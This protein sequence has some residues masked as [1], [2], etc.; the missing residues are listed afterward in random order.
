MRSPRSNRVKDIA[1]WLADELSPATPTAS[2]EAAMLL[3]A[4]SSL[5]R[6][7]QIAKDHL[8]LTAAKIA[9]LS[10]WLM[11]RQRGEPI[12]YILGSKEFYGREFAVD[13]RVLIPRPETEQIVE[14]AKDYL[15]ERR[16]PT[17][18]VLDVGTG[19]GCIAITIA[20]ECLDSVVEAW[21]ISTDALDVARRNAKTLGAAVNFS[22]MD[23][24]GV[25]SWQKASSP[26][27]ELIV[28]NPP[29]IA[30]DQAHLVEANV[31][32]FE[33]SLALFSQ[34]GLEFYETMAI[35]AGALLKPGGL[36]VCEIGFDQGA[37]VAALFRSNGWCQVEVF[38]D[39]S[40][41]DRVVR[42]GI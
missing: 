15:K 12:A 19:S 29:Y 31:A 16:L 8:E 1:R 13:S 23:A 20:L 5:T 6:T 39:L 22:Q 14:L 33:P 21:D 4:V 3:Q 25:I 34:R 32:A 17:S 37:S 28:S 26:A 27:F 36:L 40:G 24:L 18:H 11:R 2:L 42:A 38:K 30:R 7:E 9:S 35:H 10:D 41:H